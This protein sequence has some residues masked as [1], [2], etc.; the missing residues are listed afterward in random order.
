MGQLDEILMSNGGAGDVE[1]STA[2]SN[3]PASNDGEAPREGAVARLQAAAAARSR[4]ESQRRNFADAMKLMEGVAGTLNAA[5]VSP[6]GWSMFF[7]QVK[8]QERF[9]LDREAGSGSSSGGAA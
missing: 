1:W 8:A 9:I 6:D 3:R 7:H 4:D 2:A 5:N